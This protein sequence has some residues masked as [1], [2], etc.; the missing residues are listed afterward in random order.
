MIKMNCNLETNTHVFVNSPKTTDLCACG[1]HTP[2]AYPLKIKA[3]TLEI[4][5]KYA[6][7]LHKKGPFTL[8]KGGKA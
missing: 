4:W 3:M 1:L 7:I 2:G 5:P 6:Q 8:L